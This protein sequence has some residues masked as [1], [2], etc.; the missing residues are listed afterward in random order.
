MVQSCPFAQ[1]L[2]GG[3]G[4]YT[5]DNG[6]WIYSICIRGLP[7]DNEQRIYSICL[8]GFTSDSGEWICLRLF[9]FRQ[10]AVNILPI[11]H[12]QTSSGL[13]SH[14]VRASNF[15]SGGHKFESPVRRKQ[16]KT[17]WGQVFLQ[18]DNNNYLWVF[19]SSCKS[20][21]QLLRI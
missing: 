12:T 13:A 21:E 3:R 10:Q 16:W 7:S 5:S 18:S 19:F 17:A 4:E 6:E 1:S 2:C 20:I 14:F 11:G 9:H 15:R 8:R